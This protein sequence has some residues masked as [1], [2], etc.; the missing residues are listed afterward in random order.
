VWDLIV[1]KFSD[2]I[3]KATGK[4]FKINKDSYFDAL[5]KTL[6]KQIQE[7]EQ[8]K[9]DR[10][11]NGDSLKNDHLSNPRPIPKIDMLKAHPRFAE[12]MD[13]RRD[14]KASDIKYD[15]KVI[16]KGTV[17][18]DKN[19]FGGE[20]GTFVV[21]T[22][23]E[24]NWNSDFRLTKQDVKNIEAGKLTDEIVAKLDEDLNTLDTHPD[25]RILP[26][27]MDVVQSKEIL[28]DEFN[29]N[30]YVNVK[31]EIIK[32]GNL[33]FS[34][35]NEQKEKRGI[36]NVTFNDKLKT[37]IQK[38]D[39]KDVIQYEKGNRKYGAK[40][41][42]RKHYGDGKVGELTKK[43]ILEF[44]NIVRNGE[45]NK[46]S[47]R[48]TKNGISYVYELKNDKHILSVAVEETNDGAKILSGFSDKNLDTWIKKD[49]GITL[50]QPSSL[51]KEIIPQK[52]K[53]NQGDKNGNTKDKTR[54]KE[55]VDNSG[56]A[57]NSATARDNIN[58]NNDGA[59]TLFSRST[60][61]LSKKDKQMEG[62]STADD[63][64]SG[65]SKF[66]TDKVVST[67]AKTF[68][69][70]K[71]RSL[72]QKYEDKVDKV[73]D[74]I[75][76]KGLMGTLEKVS[77][78][79]KATVDAMTG[80]KYDNI[81]KNWF[82][83]TDTQKAIN[84]VVNDFN[85]LKTNIYTNANEIRK[86]LK[87]LNKEQNRDLLKVLNG[88]MKI[89]DLSDDLKPLYKTFR[90]QIDTNANELVS[91]GI[92]KED[93]KIKDYVKRY[94]KKYLED[95]NEIKAIKSKAFQKF[96]KRKDLDYDTRV[97]LG[98]IE[99]AG[100]VISNTMAEQKSLIAKAKVLKSIADKFGKD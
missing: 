20:D 59:D 26:D 28:G 39:L 73:V 27:D 91:L 8:I 1:D 45:I 68:K 79:I 80:F 96:Y 70:I 98:M 58:S 93:E 25:W 22:S 41:I 86:S 17:V 42:I 90:K 71:E 69:E 95:T 38:S 97:K 2:V 62:Q 33:L 16:Q 65:V 13:M 64:K 52:T 15:K 46:D 92:L 29:D 84:S 23:Y 54:D 94:Y 55:N 82:T 87:Y 36:Y 31:G 43:D 56:E 89:K 83:V 14:I 48:E 78:P 60:D 6:G 40:H 12:L 66:D 53:K 100:L 21:P 7:L 11:F 74:T 3:Y 4:K 37:L 76:E 49:D 67:K 51:D 34:K 24:K 63:T 75:F 19:K 72:W 30:Y 77:F 44:G 99:D 47:F 50:D 5:N 61:E 9:S 81:N 35:S 57:T 85:N 88:D 18:H 10:I 32:D